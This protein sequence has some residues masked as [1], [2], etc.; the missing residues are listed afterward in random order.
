[1]LTGLSSKIAE[2]GDS[3]VKP[4]SH[5]LD[6]VQQALHSQNGTLIVL[7]GQGEI[8]VLPQQR[9]YHANISDIAEFCHAPA[10]NFEIRSLSNSELMSMNAPGKDIRELLW[11]LAFHIYE[12]ALIPSCSENDVIQ[13][14]RWP[15]L[16]RLPVTPNT[17]R[18]C[19]LL[20]RN[21]TSITLIRR[22]LGIDRHEVNRIVSDAYSAGI[23]NTVS[24]G[25]SS[26]STEP[27]TEEIKPVQPQKSGLW[28]SLFSKISSL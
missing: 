23:V 15:N 5:L 6:I 19:A 25:P 10:A 8:K 18:I 21:P 3:A 28:N 17:A 13:F 24:R 2:K 12:D 26:M 27:A 20:T 14:N 11:Q 1:M 7:P 22:V 16:T 4:A 9:Q